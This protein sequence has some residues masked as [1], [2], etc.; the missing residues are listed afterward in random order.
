MCATWPNPPLTEHVMLYGPVSASS[1]LQLKPERQPWTS[2]GD[3]IAVAEVRLRGARA[4]LAELVAAELAVQETPRKT[5]RPPGLTVRQPGLRPA[6]DHTGLHLHGSDAAAIR[7]SR[8]SLHR[9]ACPSD[10]QLL[11]L[12]SPVPVTSAM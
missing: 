4:R 10:Y 9:D 12:A 8:V 1:R 11:S 6:A 7:A 3:K 5:L 2:T